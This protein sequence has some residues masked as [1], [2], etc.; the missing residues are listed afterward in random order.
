MSE[1]GIIKTLADGFPRAGNLLFI[2]QVFYF[3]TWKD[4]KSNAQKLD[5]PAGGLRKLVGISTK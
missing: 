2:S 4:K 5:N 3:S 1:G